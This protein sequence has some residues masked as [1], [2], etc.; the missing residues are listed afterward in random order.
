M[1]LK[2]YNAVWQATGIKDLF[3]L[4]VLL[5]LADWADDDGV[6]WPSIPTLA[7]KARQSE[8][9][10]RYIIRDLE[11]KGILSVE[12][13]RGRNRMNL[14]TL[15]LHAMQVF[16]C[17]Q[18]VDNPVDKNEKTCTVEQKTCTTE[19]ENLHGYRTRARGNRKEPLE[20]TVE[21][22]SPKALTIARQKAEEAWAEFDKAVGV[23]IAKGTRL[24][25]RDPIANRV[26]HEIGGDTV[27]ES[28]VS[29][30]SGLK[31]VFVHL[32]AQKEH[33]RFKEKAA[34]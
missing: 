28:Y 25:I 12:E 29:G 3:T 26:F 30:K 15:N 5:A 31:N 18:P 20:G 4:T 19:Q 32:Y 22:P 9:K 1:S 21:A 7:N 34:V 23:H 11:G 27:R 16:T 33:E 24:A 14:Y 6:C 10:V 13:R 2:Y 8:R 17:E